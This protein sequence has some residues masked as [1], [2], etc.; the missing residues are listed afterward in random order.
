[1]S[2]TPVFDSINAHDPD[3]EK[4]KNTPFTTQPVCEVCG[5]VCES[6]IP[7]AAFLNGW[8]VEPFFHGYITCGDCPAHIAW[9]RKGILPALPDK[10]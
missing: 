5:K 7:L 8:D 9:R 4:K 3:W 2:S 10:G 1:M 6:L